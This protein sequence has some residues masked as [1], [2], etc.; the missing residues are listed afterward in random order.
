MVFNWFFGDPYKKLINKLKKLEIFET[1]ELKD[2]D[3]QKVKDAREHEEGMREVLHDLIS[4]YEK[5]KTHFFDAK[6]KQASIL[7]KYI[8]IIKDAIDNLPSF[9]DMHQLFEEGLKADGFENELAKIQSSLKTIKEYTEKTREIV[10][11]FKEMINDK[12]VE[13]EEDKKK[14]TSMFPLNPLSHDYAPAFETKRD[15]TYSDRKK[16]IETVMKRL[17]IEAE[18]YLDTLHEKLKNGKYKKCWH[19]RVSG[20][21]NLRIIYC[22]NPS[23]KAIY[24]IEILTKNELDGTFKGKSLK[25]CEV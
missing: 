5:W 14:K 9:E 20:S 22:F 21:H 25:F 18:E 19:A 17:E 8:Y 15:K 12:E 6:A 16:A 3:H 7:N 2:L 13:E 11:T 23:T 10:E 4:N 24:Y 1:L